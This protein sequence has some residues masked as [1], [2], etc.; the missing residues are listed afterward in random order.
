MP[1]IS[2]A[3]MENKARRFA[4]L[5]N[6]D[7]ERSAVKKL[8]KIAKKRFESFTHEPTDAEILELFKVIIYSD[9]TGDEA[10]RHVMNPAECEHHESVL[11]RLGAAA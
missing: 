6:V 9:P 8:G 2:L 1:K 7:L 11:R 5:A 3:F 10:V 4:E